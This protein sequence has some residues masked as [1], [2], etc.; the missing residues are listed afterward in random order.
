MVT[1]GPAKTSTL[2]MTLFILLTSLLVKAVRDVLDSLPDQLVPVIDV[3]QAEQQQ[4]GLVAS[5]LESPQNF[6]K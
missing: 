2:K 6:L 3:G 5:Q 1:T 4:G